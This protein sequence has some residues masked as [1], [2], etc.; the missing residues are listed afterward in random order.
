V[1]GAVR[2]TARWQRDTREA[3]S[4]TALSKDE[5]EAIE[6]LVA[7]VDAG[8]RAASDPERA[9][10]EKRYLKSLLTF[11]GAG[12]PQVRAVVRRMHRAHPSLPRASVIALVDALWDAPIHER[13]LVAIEVLA[14][15]LKR[16]MS[17]PQCK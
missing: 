7:K 3:T 12:V 1:P 6:L 4:T 15:V 5:Q 8:L 2:E 14:V 11:L 17:R 10:A 9:A 13:W 16:R